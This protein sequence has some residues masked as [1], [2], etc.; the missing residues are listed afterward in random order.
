VPRL[1]MLFK[2]SYDLVVTARNSAGA[3]TERVVPITLR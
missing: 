2:G 3:T 1:A